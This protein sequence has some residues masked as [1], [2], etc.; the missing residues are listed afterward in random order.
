MYG[1][2]WCLAT[3]RADVNLP[4]SAGKRGQPVQRTSGHVRKPNSS[5][6]HEGVSLE[7]IWELRKERGG[8]LSSLS[9]KLREIGNLLTDESNLEEG[10]NKAA[11][12]YIILSYVCRSPACLPCGFDWPRSKARIRC[13]F[14]WNWKQ[15]GLLMS[16]DKQLVLSYRNESSG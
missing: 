16:N 7:R 6:D 10:E 5:L 15:F 9:A 4:N 8:V 14:H 13:L 11:R 2:S 12:N 3:L 1:L